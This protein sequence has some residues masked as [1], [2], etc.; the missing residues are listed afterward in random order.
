MLTTS[1]TSKES[2]YVPKSVLLHGAVLLVGHGKGANSLLLCWRRLRSR[3][4]KALELNQALTIGY[5]GLRHEEFRRL[6]IY[7]LHETKYALI[8]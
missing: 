2:N 1:P 7:A 8:G 5:Y 6:K 3:H 4:A